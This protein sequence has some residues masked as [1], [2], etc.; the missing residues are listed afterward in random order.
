M[1]TREAQQ[2][3]DQKRRY[4]HQLKRRKNKQNALVY[5]FDSD[6]LHN[7]VREILGEELSQQFTDEVYEEIETRKGAKICQKNLSSKNLPHNLGGV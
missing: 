1:R 4:L 6:L 2:L 3:E 5:I 7:S